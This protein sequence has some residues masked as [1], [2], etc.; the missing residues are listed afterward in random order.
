MAV[1][2]KL[3]SSLSM[4]DL[5]H[6]GCRQLRAVQQ[7][8]HRLAS[9]LQRQHGDHSLPSLAERGDDVRHLALDR[10]QR[11]DHLG[12]ALAGDVLEAAGFVDLRRRILQFRRRLAADRV[13][14]T[15][16][17]ISQL[18]RIASVAC[19]VCST[20]ASSSSVA[21]GISLVG[22][23]VDPQRRDLGLGVGDRP[24]E[25]FDF[26]QERGFLRGQ[27][28]AASSSA[29]RERP[30]L[31]FGFDAGLL[32]A[33]LRQLRFSAVMPVAASASVMVSSMAQHFF[34][35]VL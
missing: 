30:P 1:Q 3:A 34:D 32:R 17:S 7:T 13:A 27:V 35:L 6:R 16:S 22:D 15:S 19:A 5:V 11:G 18:S 2:S 25:F 29:R 33:D 23:V 8:R 20:M 12:D 28:V 9:D 31:P 14:D 21:N 4:S 24:A 10:L 26:A